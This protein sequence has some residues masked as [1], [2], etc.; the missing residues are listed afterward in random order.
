MSGNAGK[1]PPKRG[2][3]PLWILTGLCVLPVAVATAL[4]GGGW[5]PG[6]SAAHGMLVQPP[7]PVADL[8]VGETDGHPVRLGDFRAKWTLLYFG[9]ADCPAACRLDL[10]AMQRVQLAQGRER[11][12]VQRVF[13][14]QGALP[15]GA[16]DNLQRAFP[17]LAVVAA[18]RAAAPA[19]WA[20]SGRIF[21]IDPLG[22]RIMDYPAKADPGHIRQDLARLLRYSWVG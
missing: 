6:S 21:L 13:V 19:A 5:R 10:A 1:P 15:P 8:V 14:A 9:A 22:N 12:R 18:S 4:Y 17:G 16:A 3:W 11:G 20:G 2:G 7:L